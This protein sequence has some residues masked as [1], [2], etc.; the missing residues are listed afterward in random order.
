MVSFTVSRSINPHL[1]S[2]PLPGVPQAPRSPL[3]KRPACFRP[4][5]PYRFT[6][7][8]WTV[9]F[10][11]SGPCPSFSPPCQPS[12]AAPARSLLR[13]LVSK[14]CASARLGV[15]GE[16]GLAPGPDSAPSGGLFVKSAMAARCQKQCWVLSPGG[17]SHG[18]RFEEAALSPHFL[19]LCP[20]PVFRMPRQV[21]E[22]H[23]EAG[24]GLCPQ[25]LLRDPRKQC[26]S[27]GDLEPGIIC[28]GNWWR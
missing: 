6:F 18:P 17:V 7:P 3:Q 5:V 14:P 10:G 8:C 9:S 13:C 12:R 24:H 4:W 23:G 11:V 26:R 1:C 2:G 21:V 27:F 25:S 15:S 20:L 16:G 19:P 28:H 22:A